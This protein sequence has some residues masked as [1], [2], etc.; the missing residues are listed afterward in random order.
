VLA[1][2]AGSPFDLG[3]KPPSSSVTTSEVLGRQVSTAA[4]RLVF[5]RPTAFCPFAALGFHGVAGCIGTPLV[6]FD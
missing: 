2:G 6:V 5:L 3:K 4:A 1:P